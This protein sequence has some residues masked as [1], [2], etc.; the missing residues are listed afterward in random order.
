MMS[1]CVA[2]KALVISLFAENDFPEPGVPKISP[3]GFFSFFL[4]TIIILLLR[5][6]VRSGYD[7]DIIPSDLN[8]Y[9]GEAK[10]LLEDLQSRNERM[11]LVTA[12]FMN[13]AKTKQELDNGLDMQVYHKVPVHIKELCQHTVRQLR[14]YDLQI[15]CRPKGISHLEI[16]PTLEHEAGRCNKILC[17]HTR[18]Q[19]FIIGKM[20]GFTLFLIKSLIDQ[21]QSLFPA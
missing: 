15:G 9:G 14:R 16:L 10:R 21:L 19:Q 18:M 20:E 7:M 17:T 8:T 1:S 11:F 12:L 4:S 3:L 5:E 2:K 13:T 6:A